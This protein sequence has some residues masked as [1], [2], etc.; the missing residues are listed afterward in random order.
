MAREHM[1]E[2][3][4]VLRSY[5]WHLLT[6]SEHPRASADPFTLEYDIIRWAIARA[7]HPAVIELEFPA[8][9][10]LGGPTDSLDDIIECR[11]VGRDQ[12]LDFIKRKKPEWRR[13]LVAFVQSL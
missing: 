10:E 1:E 8:F 9:A 11:V 5:G 13:N 7:R 2:L 4:D 3:L 6:E 12:S